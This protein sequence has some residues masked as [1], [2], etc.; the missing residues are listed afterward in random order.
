MHHAMPAAGCSGRTYL[1][2][3]SLALA[4]CFPQV[5]AGQFAPAPQPYL[6][7]ERVNLFSHWDAP[8]VPDAFLL[9]LPDE[10]ELESVRAVRHGY[11]HVPFSVHG[12]E[13]GSYHVEPTR[14]LRGDFDVIVQV[15]APEFSAHGLSHWSMVPATFV[16]TRTGGSFV[17]MEAWRIR[18]Q[19]KPALADASTYVLRLDGSQAPLRLDRAFTQRLSGSYTLEFWLRTTALNCIVFSGWDGEQDRHYELELIIDGSGRLRYYRNVS[20]EHVSMGSERPIADGAWHHVA[21]SRDEPSAWTHL[22]VDGAAVDSLFDPGVGYLQGPPA[23]AIGSRQVPGPRQYVGDL[24]EIRLWST[25]KAAAEIQY[26]MWYPVPERTPEVSVLNFESAASR[27]S[28]LPGATAL[29]RRR[30][31][32]VRSVQPRDFSGV[33]DDGRIYLSWYS[34]HPLTREFVVERSDDGQTF[35]SVGRLPA[36]A[37]DN[38]YTFTDEAAPDKVVYYR[39]RQ[40]FVSAGEQ[41]AGTLKVGRGAEEVQETASLLGNHPNPFNPSTTISYEVLADEHVE[42]SVLDLSGHL[43][44]VLVDRRHDAGHHEV[45]FDGTDYTSGIYFVRLKTSAGHMQTRQI[46]LTK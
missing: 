17:P 37:Q 5:L 10:W 18:R 30:G 27:N 16:E 42:I 32:P 21:V 33:S 39:L 36:A 14:Y 40:R 43:I 7:G 34:D 26:A 8:D 1:Q 12:T 13:A 45:R 44:S 31:A 38:H 9:E 4:L 11:R 19:L 25:A 6:P 46:V 28:F 35:E 15:R 23:L 22:F 24:D 2:R 3:L 20:G 29:D 41:I